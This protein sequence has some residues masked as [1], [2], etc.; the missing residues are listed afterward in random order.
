MAA[1]ADGQV[2]ASLLLVDDEPTITDVL[3]R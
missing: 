1:N 3:S 2:R